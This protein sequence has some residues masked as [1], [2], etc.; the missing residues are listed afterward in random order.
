LERLDGSDEHSPAGPLR[1]RHDVDEPVRPIDEVYISAPWWAEQFNPSPLSL[2]RTGLFIVQ[3]PSV[4]GRVVLGVRL[5]LND[6]AYER[7]ASA[8][9]T[10]HALTEQVRCNI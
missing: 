7:R 10:H 8:D 1:L 9:A 6:P 2:K 3:P 5:G 4:K